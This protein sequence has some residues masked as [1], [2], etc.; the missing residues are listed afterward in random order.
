M[1]HGTKPVEYK[2]VL[3]CVVYGMHVCSM[4]AIHPLQVYKFTLGDHRIMLHNALHHQCNA[5][6]PGRSRREA[7]AWVRE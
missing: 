6:L 3:L 1:L 5:P 7:A 4:H 2:R